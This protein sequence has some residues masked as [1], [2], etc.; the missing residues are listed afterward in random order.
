MR[1][2]VMLVHVLLG[3]GPEWLRAHDRETY[4]WSQKLGCWELYQGLLSEELY[5]FLKRCLLLVEGAFRSLQGEVR[6]EDDHILQKLDEAFER[7]DRSWE[8]TS[9]NWQDAAMFASE[10]K[11]RGKGHRPVENEFAEGADD[12]GE[13]QD[14]MPD[15]HVDDD[16]KASWYIRVASMVSRLGRKMEGLLLGIKTLFVLRR[17]VLDFQTYDFRHI[18]FRCC[19]HVRR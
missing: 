19:F 5:T 10:A 9:R 2:Q 12:D 7:C 13:D 15:A 1:E 4:C 17:V 8:R 11:G 16:A 6:R 3:R 18:V 14:V